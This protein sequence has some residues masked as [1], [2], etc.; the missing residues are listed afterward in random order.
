MRTAFKN[1]GAAKRLLANEGEFSA[2]SIYFSSQS[3]E[4]S[5]K[6]LTIL[7]CGQV[8]RGHSRISIN[9]DAVAH[10]ISPEDSS[11]FNTIKVIVSTLA[12]VAGPT[13]DRPRYP[14]FRFDGLW[15]P[16]HLNH[17]DAENAVLAAQEVGN[18]CLRILKNR[19][20]RLS[21][22]MVRSAV[23]RSRPQEVFEPTEEAR[24][25]LDLELSF[26]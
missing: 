23:V 20:R 19:A 1:Y 25:L 15:S 3:A 2:E 9:V 12:A 4:K 26:G 7:E 13:Q 6:S 5:I 24:S 17:K 8:V 18:R 16:E 11:D 10:Y 14:L 22:R 21:T